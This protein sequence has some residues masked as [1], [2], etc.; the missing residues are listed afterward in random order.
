LVIYELGVKFSLMIK[1]VQILLFIAMNR[2]YYVLYVP[3]LICM[4][5]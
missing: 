1:S 5:W 4:R 2:S 3:W